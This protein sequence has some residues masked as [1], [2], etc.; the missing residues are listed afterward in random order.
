MRVILP[1]SCET[2]ELTEKHSRLY[3]VANLT[4]KRLELIWNQTIVNQR[5]NISLQQF[6]IVLI[7][8]LF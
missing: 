3:D 8:T 4:E 6:L 2:A 5:A 7:S 1:T